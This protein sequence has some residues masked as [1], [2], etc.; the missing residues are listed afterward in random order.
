MTESERLREMMRAEDI[1]RRNANAWAEWHATKI[2]FKR[3]REGIGA[4]PFRF[5]SR[6]LARAAVSLAMQR[7]TGAA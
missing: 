3:M 2:A 4:D 1:A 7:K 5:P 6:V